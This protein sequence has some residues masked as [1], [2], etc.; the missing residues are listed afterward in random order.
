MDEPVGMKVAEFPINTADLVYL[1]ASINLAA[2]WFEGHQAPVEF[3]DARPHTLPGHCIVVVLYSKPEDLYYLG[4]T[5]SK[6]KSTQ[7][8]DKVLGFVNHEIK[9]LLTF[10]AN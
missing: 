8:I 3:M 1:K 4:A 10:R 6:Q 5:M 2:K 7:W 9:E